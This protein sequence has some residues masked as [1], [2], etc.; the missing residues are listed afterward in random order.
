MILLADENIDVSVIARLRSVGHEVLAVSEMERG[1]PDE[2]VLALGNQRTAILLT[3]DKDFGE[4][5]FRQALVHAGVILIRM[6]GA[7]A[8]IKGGFLARILEEH[9]SKLV[10]AFSVV[11]RSSLRVRRREG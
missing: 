9:G 5:V 11:S 8:D 3:E 10:G 4:L 1:I 7:S 2:L 6:E